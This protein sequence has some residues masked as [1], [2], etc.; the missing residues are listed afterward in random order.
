MSP[1][2][3]CARTLL[4]LWVRCIL[5]G[6]SRPGNDWSS[7]GWQIKFFSWHQSQSHA[8]TWWMCLLLSILFVVTR[9]IQEITT[10]ALDPSTNFPRPCSNFWLPVDFSLY[11]Y[12]TIPY[13]LFSMHQAVN[14]GLSEPGALPKLLFIT[15]QQNFTC[16]F[17]PRQGLKVSFL[18]QSKERLKK[19]LK[20]CD[21][22]RPIIFLS[23]GLGPWLSL[24]GALSTP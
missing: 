22:A 21:E 24:Q 11:F 9:R 5:S 15:D 8:L 18:S 17:P 23:P 1:A 16:P 2:N 12:C 3:S 14:T 10:C 7:R 6:V 20:T 19:N 13:T 4:P